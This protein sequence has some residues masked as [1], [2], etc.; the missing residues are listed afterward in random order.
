MIRRP[1]R[2]TL[3]PYTTL[4]RSTAWKA[5][6]A[7]RAPELHGAIPLLR[8]RME[9]PHAFHQDP[10]GLRAGTRRASPPRIVPAPAHLQGGAEARQAVLGLMR[11][12]ELISHPDSLAKYM[13]AFFKMSRSSRSRVSSSAL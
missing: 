11:T 6:G 2:S 9:L 1:P 8:G 13:A 12:D 3:F 5:G 7:Q 4:F 10:I